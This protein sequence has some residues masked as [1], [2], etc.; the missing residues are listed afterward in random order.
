M[1]KDRIQG[2][3]LKVCFSI[4]FT[5]FLLGI[6]VT[7]FYIVIKWRSRPTLN[8]G[9]RSSVYKGQPWAERYW[10]EFRSASKFDYRSYVA[11]GMVPYH[12]ETIATD[13]QGMR[14]TFNSVCDPETY[15]VWMFGGSVLWG[16]GS[17]D[18]LTIPSLLAGEYSNTGRKVC[19]RNFGVSAWGSTQEIIDLGLELKRAPRGPDLVVFLDGV[20]DVFSFYQS[21]EIDV[22]QDFQRL[23]DLFEQRGSGRRILEDRLSLLFRFPGSEH[24]RLRIITDEEAK[25]DLDISYLENMRIVK[26]LAKEYGFDYAFFW[27][28]VILAGH[29]ELSGEEEAI[30]KACLEEYPGMD[31]FYLKIYALVNAEPRAR[32]FDVSG[33]FD[34]EKRT[35]YIDFTHLGPLGNHLIAARMFQILRQQGR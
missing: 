2:L 19:V 20:N 24:G 6:V 35:I 25:L 12:G 22:H 10:Q 31:L 13:Q 29:K 1:D 17:P 15:T 33:T 7:F 11:W 16:M 23:R 28:P 30:R 5:E 32:L 4:V 3:V 34:R 8:P 14:R 9:A 27:Q 18:W 26:A 21:G